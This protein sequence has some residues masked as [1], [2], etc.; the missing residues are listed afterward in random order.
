MIRRPPRS[1]LFPYTTLFRSL[2]RALSLA[3]LSVAVGAILLGGAF[4]FFFPRFNAG[5]LGRASLSPSLM[6]GFTEDVELGQIGEI[7]KS[8]ALVMRVETG[9]P[10]G[11]EWLRWRGI[12][13]AK[14][15]GKRWS[16]GAVR[17]QRLEPGGDG[18]IRSPQ[19]A[20]NENTLGQTG[21][22]TGFLEPVATD[23]I[24]VPGRFLSLQGN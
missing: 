17:P 13:L 6:T 10:I 8:K 11:Y 1:T 16:S 4:F 9:E 3:S 21:R 12:A 22:Y 18:W 2:N 7:K 23:A 24:F 19:T 14:F 5:Y 20:K 15:D